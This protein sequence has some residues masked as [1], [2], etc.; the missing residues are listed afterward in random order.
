MKETGKNK[1]NEVE[2]KL[3]GLYENMAFKQK[4]FRAS[5]LPYIVLYYSFI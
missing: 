2:C 1:E 5:F 3:R 4:S